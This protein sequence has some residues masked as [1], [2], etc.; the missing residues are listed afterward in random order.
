MIK[1]FM[2]RVITTHVKTHSSLTLSVLLV[3]AAQFCFQALAI[4][5]DLFLK[6]LSLFSP[7]STCHTNISIFVIPRLTIILTFLSSLAFRE[8]K[9]T[10]L[11]CSLSIFIILVTD[12]K[13]T[14]VNQAFKLLGKQAL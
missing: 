6:I 9:L 10:F 11:I 8:Y 4:A 2:K 3:S 5:L 14:I 7:T 1:I 13:Y 12:M